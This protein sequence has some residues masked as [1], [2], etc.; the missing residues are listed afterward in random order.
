MPRWFSLQV[1]G[2]APLDPGG[3]VVL[4]WRGV[5]QAAV[6]DLGPAAQAGALGQRVQE[7]RVQEHPVTAAGGEVQ[8]GVPAAE[9]Q[10][11]VHGQGEERGHTE[12]SVE[13]LLR[14]C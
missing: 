2:A 13:C 7:Q 10:V 6:A 4:R 11:Q 3:R 8:P 1:L 12:E 9:G 5:P 14:S